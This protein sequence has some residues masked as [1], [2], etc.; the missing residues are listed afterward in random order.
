[1]S[2]VHNDCKEWIARDFAAAQKQAQFC[3]GRFFDDKTFTRNN[4]F[5]YLLMQKDVPERLAAD[6]IN[7]IFFRLE[8]GRQNSG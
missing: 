7:E 5:E 6:F 8:P 3:L 2:S 1:M 4:A